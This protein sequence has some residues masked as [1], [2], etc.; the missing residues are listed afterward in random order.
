MTWGV[1]FAA[2]LPRWDKLPWWSDF[3]AEL[4][5]MGKSYWIFD[6]EVIFRKSSEQFD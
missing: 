4:P 1:D 2:A 3:A 6:G 5:R